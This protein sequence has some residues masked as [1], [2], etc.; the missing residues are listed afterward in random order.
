MK[1]YCDSCKGALTTWGPGML[2]RT[3]LNFRIQMRVAGHK[4]P[5]ERKEDDS[6]TRI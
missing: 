3:T 5:W 4:L 6:D 2:Y 1:V